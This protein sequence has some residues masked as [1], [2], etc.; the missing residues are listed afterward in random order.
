LPVVKYT[1]HHNTAIAEFV[2][3]LDNPSSELH[4]LCLRTF[5]GVLGQPGL[6]LTKN[7][8]VL[9]Q[10]GQIKGLAL[11]FRGFPIGRS[12]VEVMTMPELS[13]SP[14]EID[15]V[16]QSVAMAESQTLSV[17]HICVMADSG[18]S[19]VQEQAGFTE[20]RTYL[21]MLWGTDELAELELPEGYSLAVLPDR[22]HALAH[23]GPK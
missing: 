23:P 10:S 11:I 16:Q 18:M 6:D 2:A 8:L 7:C 12:I 22:R 17:L 3:S 4:D 20:V 15:L 14:D 9:K 5:Q 1:N 19:R 21:D 13:S